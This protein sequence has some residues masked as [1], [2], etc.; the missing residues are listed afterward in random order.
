MYIS[1]QWMVEIFGSLKLKLKSDCHDAPISKR[2]GT[3]VL[4]SYTYEP[5]LKRTAAF[6][7][8]V[9]FLSNIVGL[10]PFKRSIVSRAIIFSFIPASLL[11]AIWSKLRKTVLSVY[12]RAL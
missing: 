1:N 12:G 9:L 6:F 5:V 11:F 4:F 3:L 8:A 10:A 7:A 2:M